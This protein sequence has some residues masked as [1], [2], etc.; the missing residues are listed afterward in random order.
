MIACTVRIA[1]PAVNYQLDPFGHSVFEGRCASHLVHG[2]ASQGSPPHFAPHFARLASFMSSMLSGYSG[3]F[4]GRISF[5]DMAI[6]MKE[7]TMEWIWTPSPT[8]GDAGATFA[9][10]LPLGYG[11][12]TVR[13]Q[14]R[15]CLKP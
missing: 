14:V 5:D 11:P 4:W 12:P 15:S 10:T 8:L 7:G 3:V 1:L 6:R 13:G 2:W 9:G